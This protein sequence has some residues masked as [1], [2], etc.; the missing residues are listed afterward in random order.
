[1]NKRIWIG[2]SAA[3]LCTAFFCSSNFG[4]E[5]WPQQ[6]ATQKAAAEETNKLEDQ[7]EAD[8]QPQLTEWAAKGKPFIPWAAKPSDLPQ[9][10]IP[11][12]P[13]A[14]G[15]GMYSFGG[16][17]GKVIVVS[18]LE[19]SGPGTLRE[20]CKTAGP[21]IVV[22]NVAGIIHLQRRIEVIAPYISIEGQS[23]PGDGVC[24]AGDT[25]EINTHDAVIRYM[26]F[27][28]GNMDVYNRND[29]LGGDP[30]GNI[31]VDHASCSW[32][33][34]ENLSMYRHMY[35]LPD[36]SHQYKLPT[37]N[38]TLQWNI[39]S[40]ALDTYNH[41]FGGTWG[42]RNDVFHHNLFACDTGRNCSMG[43]GGDFNY[44]NNVVF[45]WRHRTIDGGDD[46]S[47]VNIINNYFKP[48]PITPDAPI[49]YR[50]VKPDAKRGKGIAKQYGIFYVIGNIVSDN[51]MV[52]ADNW[53]GGVQLG[54]GSDDADA[55]TQSASYK[56]PVSQAT[57]EMIK[58]IKS[59]HSFPLAPVTIQPTLEAYDSVLAGAGA[60][61]PR[62]DPVDQRVVQEVQ[63]GV[64]TY[65]K[66]ILTNIDQVGGYPKYE[67][68]PYTGSQAVDG[69]PDWWKTKYGLKLDDPSVATQDN[70]G[71]GYTNIEKFLGGMDPT[72]KYDLNVLANNVNTLT[73]DQLQPLK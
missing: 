13:G 26:R 48:G 53:A 1:M 62:R 39:S 52:T 67:G 56:P 65:G 73:P 19:D 44:I 31:L 10:G 12:F 16:R 21:R 51:P 70:A 23:A 3:T 50:I 63:T 57:P 20:A 34:D 46:T 32:G 58:E 6:S 54:E 9:A 5:K 18:S 25:L 17:G 37:V 49:R 43:L 29:G 66:G 7:E 24:V 47:R 15:G 72:K 68:A 55:A 59:D 28:R 41:A 33:F 38:I 45:N 64:V 8:L 40:E 60:T 35:V 71:D 4:R 2:L 42:G 69:I 30:V 61:L 27:R 36:K 22:F 11:A 14:Q